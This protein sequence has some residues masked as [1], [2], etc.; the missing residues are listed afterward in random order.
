MSAMIRDTAV[1][2]TCFRLILVSSILIIFFQSL[3]FCIFVELFVFFS[4]GDWS[5][6][7]PNEAPG[8]PDVFGDEFEALYASHEA[9]G[10]A[11]RTIKARLLWVAI[12]DAQVHIQYAICA[13][14][15]WELRI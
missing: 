12:M 11:R 7:C 14:R 10:L 13:I 4:D 2:R 8:L 1:V 6:F 5:L 3:F 15:T 9:K